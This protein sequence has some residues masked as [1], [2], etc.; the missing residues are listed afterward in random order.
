M[1]K[2]FLKQSSRG[3]IC[4]KYYAVYL[5]SHYNLGMEYWKNISQTIKVIQIDTTWLYFIPF[6]DS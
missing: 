3:S 6:G 1:D 2:H 4:P 5:T